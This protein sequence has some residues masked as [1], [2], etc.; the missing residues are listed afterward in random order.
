M[1]KLNPASNTHKDGSNNFI[2]ETSM[3]I[4][5]TTTRPKHKKICSTRE[6][7]LLDSWHILS[8]LRWDTCCICLKKICYFTLWITIV[9]WTQKHGA[10][11]IILTATSRILVDLSFWMHRYHETWTLK[12]WFGTT[13]AFQTWQFW[14]VHVNLRRGLS[15]CFWTPACHNEIQHSKHDGQ[16]WTLGVKLSRKG[17][18]LLSPLVGLS[19]AIAGVIAQKG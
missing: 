19:W 4:P 3:A 18:Q 5:K 15:W 13:F 9:W 2:S 7:S 8:F 12:W 17:P 10:L 6:G 1:G 11:S 14:G 16:L